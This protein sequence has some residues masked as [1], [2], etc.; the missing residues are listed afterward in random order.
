[1]TD[2]ITIIITGICMGFG[3]GI[4]SYLATRYAIKHLEKQK[5]KEGSRNIFE[6]IIDWWN[7]W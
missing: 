4:G 7:A 3:T 6:K 1:M 5:L 2:W